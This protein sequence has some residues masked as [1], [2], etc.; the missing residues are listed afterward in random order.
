MAKKNIKNVVL[1]LEELDD[2]LIATLF[3]RGMA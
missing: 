3:L 2:D 1:A